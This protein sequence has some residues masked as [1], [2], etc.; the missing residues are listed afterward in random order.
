MAEVNAYLGE[1]AP[2]LREV[3]ELRYVQ[4][5]SQEET[6]S[7]LRISRQTLRTR[8]KHLREG[9]RRRLTRLNLVDRL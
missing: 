2:D 8:E 7:A 5:R 3:H 4:C 6:C 9:L 1:L